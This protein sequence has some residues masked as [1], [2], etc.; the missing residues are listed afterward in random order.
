MSSCP[1]VTPWSGGQGRCTCLLAHFCFFP[2]CEVVVELQFV[3]SVLSRRQAVRY[4]VLTASRRS[5]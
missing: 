3:Q 1:V 5:N 4:P 2:F